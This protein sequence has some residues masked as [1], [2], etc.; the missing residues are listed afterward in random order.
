MEQVLDFFPGG[1][2]NVSRTNHRT[3][4]MKGGWFLRSPGLKGSRFF[5]AGVFEVVGIFGLIPRLGVGVEQDDVF[6]LIEGKLHSPPRTSCD[7]FSVGVQ[8]SE[9]KEGVGFSG[10]VVISLQE[11][12]SVK[13]SGNTSTQLVGSSPYGVSGLHQHFDR[14]RGSEL[15]T[16]MIGRNHHFDLHA[17]VLGRVLG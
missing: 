3:T 5:E 4:L 7:G 15:G 8:L 13:V 16:R 17:V 10:Q 1:R 12:E 2:T 14:S 6:P 11:G 9:G